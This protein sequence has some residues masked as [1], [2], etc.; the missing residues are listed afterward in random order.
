MDSIDIHREAKW[1]G[2]KAW[3]H[4]DVWE[5]ERPGLSERSCT[6]CGCEGP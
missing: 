4:A 5:E 2:A 3:L 1:D 6:D